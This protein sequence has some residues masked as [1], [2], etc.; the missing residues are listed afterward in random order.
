[1]LGIKENGVHALGRG[2]SL[3]DIVEI[4]CPVS[5]LSLHLFYFDSMRWML[6]HFV[7]TIHIYPS[8]LGSAESVWTTLTDPIPLLFQKSWCSRG[9]CGC[10]TVRCSMSPLCHWVTKCPKW[11]W[12]WIGKSSYNKAICANSFRG[13]SEMWSWYWPP[14]FYVWSLPISFL[15]NNASRKS[16]FHCGVK[17]E[18]RQ[19]AAGRISPREAGKCGVG[20]DETVTSF[21]AILCRGRARFCQW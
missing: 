15:A 13:R 8:P 12:S 16:I 6:I 7:F 3:P 2:G 4:G 9:H 5:K 1:M 11:K 21:K 19:R 20:F 17:I 14:E 10:L 18:R